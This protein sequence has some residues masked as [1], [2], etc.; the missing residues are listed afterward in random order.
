M[1]RP[2][3]KV[4]FF[5]AQ[6]SGKGTQAT[7]LHQLLGVPHISPGDIFRKAIR[8]GTDLGKAVENIINDGRLVPNEITNTLM[9]NRLHQSDAI[10]GFILDGYPRNIAQADALDAVTVLTHVLVIDIDDEESVKRISVRRV[11]HTCGHTTTLSVDAEHQPCP[12][13]GALLVHRDDDKPDA[14]RHRLNIY[15]S[16]TELLFMRY[17]ERGILTHV[18]GRGTIDEVWERL[19]SLFPH[20]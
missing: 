15:H 14:I 10:S 13:C 2:I 4:C 18:D 12:T 11:C 9:K 5:G 1:P 19:S 20:V 17:E 16:Q 7:R 8:E 3:Y 6:G